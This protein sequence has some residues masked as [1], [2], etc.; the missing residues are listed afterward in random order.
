MNKLKHLAIILDGNRRW[1]KD[2]KLTGIQGHTKGYENVKKIG[3]AALDRDV[4]YFSVYAFSTENWS[5]APKEV[6]YLM[7]LLMKALTEELDFYLEN[8]V[9]LKIVGRMEGFSEKM[10]SAIVVAEE[11]TK[12]GKRGQ[13]NLCVNYGGRAEIVD[14]VKKMIEEGVNAI[15]EDM[16]KSFMCSHDIPDPDLIVRTSGEKRLSGFLTWSGVYSE[17]KFIDKHWPDFSVVDLDEC[18]EDFQ[19]RQRRFGK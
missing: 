3:L 8:D 13:F 7:N 10:K 2:H 15:D 4:E 16:F 6:E 5:R 17:L 14:A 11:T 12:D 19:N 18:I 9:R 1:A